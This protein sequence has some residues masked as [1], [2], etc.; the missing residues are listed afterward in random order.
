M[1]EQRKSPRLKSLY[2]GVISF[3]EDNFTL[4]CMVRDISETGARLRFSSPPAIVSEYLDLDIP[5]KART[6]HGKVVRSNGTEMGV[7]FETNVG[8]SASPSS[9]GVTA[10]H[11]NDDELSYRVTRLEAEITALKQMIKRL[12]RNASDNTETA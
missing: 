12:Q 8:V 11:S 1:T 9:G 4:D 7:A 3:G 6:Y 2:R 5:I 10:S